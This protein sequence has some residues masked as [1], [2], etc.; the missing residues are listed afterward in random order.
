MNTLPTQSVKTDATK[1]MESTNNITNRG[2][3]LTFLFALLMKGAVLLKKEQRASKI[4]VPYFPFERIY[5]SNGDIFLDEVNIEPDLP[6]NKK[7]DRCKRK[8]LSEIPKLLE[9][10]IRFEKTNTKKAKDEE[11]TIEPILKFCIEH[12]N[13]LERAVP[14]ELVG[15]ISMKEFQDYIGKQICELLKDG[16]KNFS[17]GLK[18][19]SKKNIHF[20]LCSRDFN[21]SNFKQEHPTCFIYI[22]DITLPPLKDVACNSFIQT[23]DSTS[24]TNPIISEISKSPLQSP[25]I[26]S[27]I[28]T[29]SPQVITFSTQTNEPPP[30]VSFGSF[31]H[32]AGLFPSNSLDKPLLVISNEYENNPPH[33]VVNLENHFEYLMSGFNTLLNYNQEDYVDSNSF[34]QMLPNQPTSFYLF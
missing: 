19:A 24:E 6:Q 8:F 2:Y 3:T 33:A 34:I 28:N 15:P 30:S 22:D 17:I 1:K 5:D 27:Q 29:L 7:T 4:G 26:P 18:K 25:P 14:D 31:C 13:K 16:L 23:P 32:D 21:V 11:Y 20:L 9:P 10:G 12:P